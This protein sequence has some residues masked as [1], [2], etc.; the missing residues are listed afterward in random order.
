MCAASAMTAI[1]CYETVRVEL[2]NGGSCETAAAHPA[3]C[4]RSPTRGNVLRVDIARITYVEHSTL[5]LTYYK[6][7][8]QH[9]C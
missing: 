5:S 9:K 3:N 7:I 6:A 1:V 2:S 8:K 4:G